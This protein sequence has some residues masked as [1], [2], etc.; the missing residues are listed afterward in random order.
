MCS[1]GQEGVI[2]QQ[3]HPSVCLAPSP[4]GPLATASVLKASPEKTVSPRGQYSEGFPVDM[5]Q[6]AN[7]EVSPVA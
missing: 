2:Q 1:S 7:C 4:S 3:S 5:M 6:P